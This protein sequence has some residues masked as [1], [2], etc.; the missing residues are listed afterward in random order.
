LLP[1]DLHALPKGIYM[2]SLVFPGGKTMTETKTLI[3]E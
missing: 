3:K 1:L 2:V